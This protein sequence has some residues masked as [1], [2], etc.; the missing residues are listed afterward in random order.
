VAFCYNLRVRVR[1]TP[2]LSLLGI[3][4]L[5]GSANAG[6]VAPT[7][8]K[9][10][11][12]P[13]GG[14]LS[15]VSVRVDA[16]AKKLFF[17]PSD[18]VAID[19]ADPDVSKIKYEPVGLGGGRQ[20]L[21]VVIPSSSRPSVAFEALVAG[22]KLVFSGGTGFGAT[23]EGT[24]NRIQVEGTSVFV[25]KLRR[26]LTV[27]GMSETLLEPRRLDP[28]TLELRR[29]AMHRI[30][31]SVR[32]DSKTL[33]ATKAEQAPVASLLSV[34]GASVHD[35]ASTNLADGDDNTTWT[36]TLKGDGKGEFVVF[37]ANKTMPIARLSL[38]LEPK[39]KPANYVAPTSLFL[40]VDDTTYRIAIP[41]NPGARVDIPFPE[42]IKTSCL[43][44]SLDAEGGDD[45]T[46][47]LAE[48]EAVPVLPSTV[49][50]I[51]DLVTLLDT[52]GP[53]AD[54]AQTLLDNAG[55][56][57]AKAIH[58]KLAALGDMGRERAV[59][60]LDGSPCEAASYPLAV[61][62]Y[63]APKALAQK[64]RGTLDRCGVAATA[65]LAET[66]SKGPDG[67][68]E[69]LAERWAKVDPKNA[70]PAIL[71]TIRKA[72]ATRRH[73]FRIALSRVPLKTAGRDAIAEWLASKSADVSTVA[74]GEVDPAI[75]LGRAIAPVPELG[76]TPNLPGTLAK[77]LLT[78]NKTFDAQWLGAQPLADLAA[79]G[80]VSA[81]AAVR[82]LFGMED[83]YL[84]ARAVEVSGEIEALRPEV[85]AALKDPDPRVRTN[86]LLALRKGSGPNGAIAPILGIL[87]DDAWTY[88]RVAAAETLAEAKGGADVDVALG[89]ATEDDLPAVRSAAIRALVTRGARSQL[90]AIRKRAFDAK[91]LV[92][93]RGEAITALGQLCDR[94][95]VEELF[96]IAKRGSSSEGAHRLALSAVIALGEIHP[97]DLAQRLS[98]LDQSSL[99]M[100]DAIRRALKTTSKCK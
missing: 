55:A 30:S 57:G 21:R 99:V 31:A 63:E 74:A 38:L 45:P 56:R 67:A 6:P 75:E 23:G 32:K 68:K 35:G 9:T 91:E 27:C 88:V 89:I 97:K 72:P 29:V 53:N 73:T 50:K 54:L 48:V 42:P 51:E 85:I 60:I 12:L 46:I 71:E 17:S 64:A 28:K 11:T 93:V 96:D 79:R 59:E 52:K 19:L 40:S 13:A 95:S 14:G 100:K 44:I 8:P 86:A 49:Q 84:R 70:L 77:V 47:G 62:A 36:E 24:G 26:E 20:L 34:R 81:L 3:G 18:S 61:L 80:D 22:D 5:L 15:A 2:L 83:R 78:H 37:A 33:T 7:Q 98:T 10:G 69:V 94:D 82:A 90:P 1:L 76:E 41:S 87:K 39:T 92:D 43:A 66:Y 65:A 4:A 16:A 25:G 58:S